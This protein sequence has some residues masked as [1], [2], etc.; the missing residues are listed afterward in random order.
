MAFTL[1]GCRTALAAAIQAV[2]GV[3]RVHDYRRT[4]RDEQTVRTHLWDGTRINGWMISPSGSNA[5]INVRNPGFD[6]IGVQGGGQMMTTFQLQ[7][8][9]Y[10]GL[11]DPGASER[12]FADL[13][14]AVA[15][16]L[17]RY[18]TLAIS[19]IVHQ[20]PADVEQFG[21]AM[22]ANFY[23]VHYCRIGI[24]FQGKTI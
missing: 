7:A 5:G 18:G 14:E 9:G 16:H 24:G 20:L 12:V 4:M 8:E 22:F 6:G 17:N 3:G 11:D 19:G 10:Y 21:Y 15:F 2:P 23:L 1:N 13:A